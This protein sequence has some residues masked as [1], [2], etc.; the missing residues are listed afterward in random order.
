MNIIS[1]CPEC[2]SS[3]SDNAKGCT[4]GWIQPRQKNITTNFRC[5]FIDEEKR[6]DL[7]GSICPS[8]H[9]NGSWYCSEH[10]RTLN[11]S[12]AKK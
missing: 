5:N 2:K 8:T 3:L 10:W 4:C 11:D 1:L 12:H 7:P 6:C 9:G